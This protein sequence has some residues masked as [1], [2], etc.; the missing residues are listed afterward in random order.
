[1]K[2]ANIESVWAYAKKKLPKAAISTVQKTGSSK[3]F[4]ITIPKALVKNFPKDASGDLE[5]TLTETA[6]ELE[7]ILEN[8]GDVTTIVDSK[9]FAD[10]VLVWAGIN[11]SLNESAETY[12]HITKSNYDAYGIQADAYSTMCHITGK[13]DFWF[14]NRYNQQNK[15]NPE[16]AKLMTSVEGSKPITSKFD[17]YT[18]VHIYKLGDKKILIVEPGQSK[19]DEHLYMSNELY[20]SIESLNEGC[21]NEG[22]LKMKIRP[23]SP[24]MMGDF[25]PAEITFIQ[26]YLGKTIY[27][28]TER[29][30]YFKEIDKMLDSKYLK[31]TKNIAGFR[32][33]V[34][35]L[36]SGDN[37]IKMESFYGDSAYLVGSNQLNEN[38]IIGIEDASL[39][40]WDKEIQ[41]A[42]VG[43]RKDLAKQLDKLKKP[44]F[45]EMLPSQEVNLF[46]KNDDVNIFKGFIQALRESI[47]PVVEAVSIEVPEAKV[48]TQAEFRA[49]FGGSSNVASYMLQ[50][51]YNPKLIVACNSEMKGY[52]EVKTFAEL[53]PSLPITGE[54]MEMKAYRQ[55]DSNIFIV[56]PTAVY[57]PYNSGTNFVLNEGELMKST[58][59]IYVTNTERGVLSDDAIKVAIQTLSGQMSELSTDPAEESIKAYKEC[60][61]EYQCLIGEL[62]KRGLKIN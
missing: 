32:Y 5:Y 2:F 28:V 24:K 57:W 56:T 20:K 29:N 55:S 21:I 1:M 38:A 44:Y 9:D 19:Y 62:E 25:E 6:G 10:N 13:S 43:T 16:I 36:P 12:F 37:V 18:E 27:Q 4:D 11:E 33:F 58:G 42:F 30:R 60:E 3:F 35:A 54:P 48:L 26:S 39:Q 17:N 23:L 15:E 41:F 51:M 8:T 61:D 14:A 34:W 45:I 40:G 52:D 47:S 50:T 53:H 22:V 59:K 31:D 46:I 7:L 49:Q